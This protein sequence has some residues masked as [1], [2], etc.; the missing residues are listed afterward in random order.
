ML[1]TEL[2]FQVNHTC[3]YGGEAS[4]ILVGNWSKKKETKNT[5]Y[6][7][8]TVSASSMQT[9]L[10]HYCNKAVHTTTERCTWWITFDNVF[11]SR[12]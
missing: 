2:K 5:A 11:V 10:H 1:H 3:F 7:T 6:L 9:R 4:E 8:T 12:S